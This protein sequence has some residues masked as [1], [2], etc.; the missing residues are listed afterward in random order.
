MLYGID[1]KTLT[2]KSERRVHFVPPFL[3][4]MKTQYTIQIDNEQARIIA[5]ALEDELVRGA[6]DYAREGYGFFEYVSDF[7]EEINIL[8]HFVN[9]CSYF[10]SP[11]VPNGEYHVHVP[12]LDTMQKKLA[13]IYE[14]HKENTSR[15]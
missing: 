12:E 1:S 10:I 11:I 2:M 7:N 4:K 5:H 3:I 9:N 6:I 14:T 8:E 13:Y 15:H